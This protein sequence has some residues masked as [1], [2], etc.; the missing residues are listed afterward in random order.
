M[1]SFHAYISASIVEFGEHH[2]SGP[3]LAF[4]LVCGMLYTACIVCMLGRHWVV[5][6]VGFTALVTAVMPAYG[7]TIAAT[8][9]LLFVASAAI[10]TA[11]LRCHRYPVWALLG[12]AVAL[13][14]APYISHFCSGETS[15]TSSDDS[16]GTTLVLLLPFSAAVALERSRSLV[17]K[18]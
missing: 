15:I 6:V 13:W 5:G 4:H 8:A 7:C 11:A 16:Y 9:A 14:F 3:N 17:R 1:W 10:R 2:R 12:A 18:N